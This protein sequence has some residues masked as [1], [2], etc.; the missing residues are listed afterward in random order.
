MVKKQLIAALL[1]VILILSALPLACAETEMS[2]YSLPTTSMIVNL[3]FSGGK[4]IATAECFVAANQTSFT[5]V[6]LQKLIGDTWITIETGM[7]SGVATTSVPLESGA[8]Y[9][10]YGHGTVYD[11]DGNTIDTI[12]KYTKPKT[13]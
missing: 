10:A 6:S 8:S 2:L 3:S 4:A 9:R 1:S 12:S 7:S 11:K 13:N 5:S